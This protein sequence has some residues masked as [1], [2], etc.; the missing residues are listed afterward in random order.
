MIGFA[1]AFTDAPGD[2]VYISGDTVWYD[3]VVE[4]GRRFPP[5]VAILFM[6]A[7]RVREAGSHHLTFTAEEGVKAARLF[8]DA[9]I[10]PLHFE[11]WA[12]FSESRAGDRAGLRCVRPGWP[13][14]M[15]RCRRAALADRELMLSQG[16]Q[17]RV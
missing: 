10:V 15:A 11:G 6:G 1:L 16:N 9:V 17:A 8:A 5:R 2:L 4:V 13:P 12:H 3:G 7:A 14:A